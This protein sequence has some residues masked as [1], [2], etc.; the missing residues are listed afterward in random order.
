MDNMEIKK[1]MAEQLEA[2][3]SLSDIQQMVNEKF[4][5]KFSYME[6]RIMAADLENIDWTKNDPVP[7]EKKEDPAKTIPPGAADG[8]TVVE[9]SKL[10]RPGAMMNGTVKFASGA[11]AT[12]ILDRS[13]GLGFDDLVGEPTEDDTKLF[14]EELKKLLGGPR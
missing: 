9:I 8:N 14:L 13:G 10:M 5:K 2:G 6:I 7:A 1:F 4:K 11:S 12:W 3:N